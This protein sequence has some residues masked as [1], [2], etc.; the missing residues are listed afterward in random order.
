MWHC[1]IY[2]IIIVHVLINCMYMY[3]CIQSCY[4]VYMYMCT[5]GHVVLASSPGHF[6]PVF[7]CY[8]FFCVYISFKIDANIPFLVWVVG[9]GNETSTRPCI[10][11]AIVRFVIVMMFFSC[12]TVAMVAA[13]AHQDEPSS[14]TTVSHKLSSLGKLHQFQQNE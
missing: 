8:P 1:V 6:L 12:Y 2:N 4:Q 11:C 14:T 3:T 7:Q 13:A 5:H 9:S 10:M